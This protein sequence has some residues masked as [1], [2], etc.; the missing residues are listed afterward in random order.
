MPS[1]RS[2]IVLGGALALTG[3]LVVT[4]VLTGRAE[5]ARTAP[6]QAELVALIEARQSL[7]DDLDAAVGR[8]RTEVGG[9]QR[10]V[11]RA[12]A[13]EKETADRLEALGRLAGTT[14]LRGP[15]LVVELAPSDRDPPSADEA[16]AYDIHDSDVQL[17]VNAL[18]AAGA[19]AVAVNDSRLVATTPIRA[20][21]DTIVV[22]FRPLVPPYRIAAIGAD[23]HQFASSDI[24]RRFGRW[25]DL[26]GLGF[27][28]EEKASIT[29]PGYT[30]RVSISAATPEQQPTPTPTP[31]TTAPRSAGSVR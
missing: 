30:G 2:S 5:R 23:R 9:E 26:F 19:E 28:V 7:V 15:G 12:S 29:V 1:D 27:D 4:A 10:R 18:F 21:G 3:F 17:V 6:R 22:N 14:A 8:L 31:A 25:T 24:A 20:A 13:V 11:S 16:G